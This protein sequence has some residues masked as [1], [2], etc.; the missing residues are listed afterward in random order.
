MAD[1]PTAP[2]QGTAGS[3]DVVVA[4][5]GIIRQLTNIYKNGQDI[6]TAIN[7]LQ[8]RAFGSF[9]LAAAATTTVAQA[10]VKANGVVLPIP[11]NAAAATL[12]GS[13]K[14]LY[15]SSI[16]PGVSFT[17][18]TGNASAAVGTETFSYVVLNPV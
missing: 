17:F 1:Q 13:A 18:A 8:A 14:S 3:T 2:G 10:A 11:T 12:M 6:I 4:L 15:L 7:D 9:T 16:S 5:Q